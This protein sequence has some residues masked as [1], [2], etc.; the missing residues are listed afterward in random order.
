ME[1]QRPDPD[2][3]LARVRQ[4][5]A[6][7]ARGK[8][9]IFFGAAPGV[10]KTYAMLEAGRKAAKEGMDV[11]VG[12]V[13]PHAR[14][15][16]QTLVLGLDMLAR[17]KVE[18]KGHTILE[19]DLDA[20]LAR[21]PQLILVDELAHTNAAGS[22]HEKRWQDIDEL[23]EAGINV[24]TTVNVQHIES[25]NDVVAQI[26]S[27]AVRETVPDSIFE[28]ADEV[29]LVDIAPDDL[30][31]RLR[32]GKVYL[33]AQAHRA[34]EH[35][36]R[37][38]NLIAL[39][40][41]ALRKT[42]DRVSD[43]ALI[44]RHEQDVTTIW[45]SSERLL[46]LVS[47]SPMSARLVRA[48]R[49]M[50]ASLRANWTAL[51]YESANARSLDSSSS[52]R[53]DQ[54][55]RLAEQLGGHIASVAGASF[56]DTVLDFARENNVTRIIVGKPLVPRWMEWFQGAHV[57]E[58]IRKCG[59]IDVYVI[60]GDSGEPLHHEIKVR[61]QT[62][63][64]IDYLWAGLMVVACT[65]ICWM[66]FPFFAATNLA[67]LYLAIVVAVSLKLG[68]GAS[69]MASILSVALF[70]VFFVPP[71]GTL[72][73][74]DT[75][76]I[77]TFAVMLITGLVISEL[78]ARVRAQAESARRRER[79]TRAL[80]EMSEQLSALPTQ[81]AVAQ[82]ASRILKSSL[83]LDSWIMVPI[84]TGLV[85]ADPG[86]LATPAKDVGVIKWVYEHRR[87]AGY[88]TQTL[89]GSDG[90]YL[91]L[92]VTGGIVGVLGVH[93]SESKDVLDTQ[94]IQLLEAFAGQLAVVIERCNLAVSAEQIRLQMETEKMR[95][96]LLSAVSHD[97]RTPL[98]TITGAASTL[99][100]TNT[101]LGEDARQEL[102][103]SIMDEG[104]RL[105]R[106]VANL[107]DMTR[108]DGGA[109]VLHR[110][111]QPIEEVI[112]VVL[113]RMNRELR[114][115]KV[116]T[117]VP[118]DL[119]P[120]PI[121]D[122]LIQQVF[123]NLLDNA[124]KFSPDGGTITISVRRHHTLLMVQVADQGPGVP[125]GEESKIFDKFYRVDGQS[126]SGSG[127]GLAICRGIVYLHGGTI[128]AL[129]TSDGGAI[130]EFSLPIGS[131]SE[132]K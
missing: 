47:A 62:R 21:K 52:E 84:E 113:Q 43:Q 32:E 85:S 63:P 102:A 99:A 123:F 107:L 44:Y 125:S 57:Y 111:L 93:R 87:A 77:F 61:R 109:I 65:A 35:F 18:Y 45:P 72:A 86:A 26:T 36:F 126:R 76:Y 34:I 48:T 97:L 130:F 83:G 41:L 131:D 60:S 19:F 121:D 25:L 95:N 122:L 6:K 12:Y 119:P 88:G 24:F 55:L 56:A 13:E 31:D 69:I 70:D 30:I 33:P 53:L 39:R 46:V 23:L 29:E 124:A 90:I 79:R 110:E 92:L 114:T 118:D 67:M 28:K 71:Y 42:T 94:Q 20:A 14:P 11:V 51:H 91:P 75:Q 73:V 100:A 105:N 104:H 40:E 10:G 116:V 58:L 3:L 112:G 96:S 5:E 68:R 15:E 117:D 17:R 132:N 2:T 8:L 50:A 59:E 82:T 108:L 7:A 120:V 1:N 74:S 38:G 128:R 4:D 78:T 22:T 98:A 89:P 49:R 64:W 103:E 129:P 115:Y 101:H 81:A 27:V 66:L 16:T 127:I 106:L 54:N 80:F 9:K 37:K